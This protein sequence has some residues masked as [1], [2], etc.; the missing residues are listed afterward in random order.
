MVDQYTGEKTNEI[1]EDMGARKFDRE[2]DMTS[3]RKDGKTRNKMIEES[4]ELD[5]K[6]SHGKKVFL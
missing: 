5:S 6:F 2:K 4:K 1:I 3:H